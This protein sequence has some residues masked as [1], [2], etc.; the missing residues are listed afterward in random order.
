MGELYKAHQWYK[1]LSPTYK[2][3]KGYGGWPIIKLEPFSD[4]TVPEGSVK[5]VQCLAIA[6]KAGGDY[7][8]YQWYFNDDSADYRPIDDGETYSG[9]AE[10]ILV[11]NSMSEATQGNY[12]CRVAGRKGTVDTQVAI[13]RM[14]GREA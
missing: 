6:A 2:A 5:D 12:F 4:V 8:E 9:T 1:Q 7:P 10:P 3:Y 11:I 13:I 14:D